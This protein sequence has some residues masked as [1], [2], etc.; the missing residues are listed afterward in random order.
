[1]RMAAGL[2][3]VRRDLDGWRNVAE[4]S[5]RKR[6]QWRRAATRPICGSVSLS[7]PPDRLP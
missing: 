6:G 2:G 4:D 1:M 3:I 7:L 5:S